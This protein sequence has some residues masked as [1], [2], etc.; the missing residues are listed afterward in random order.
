MY[1]E[2]GEDEM[3]SM[4]IALDGPAGAGKST[5]AK[6]ISEIKNI[7]YIDTGAMYRA[8]ALKVLKENIDLENQDHIEKMLL[9]TKIDIKGND[10]FLDGQM[11]TDEIRNPNV[12]KMVSHV[13]KILAVREKMTYL[14]R[15]IAS[16]KD[17]VMDGRDIGTFVLPNA[18]YKFYLTA[19]IE[20]RAERRYIELKEKG[21]EV[22]LEQIKD[23]I[24]ERDK[25]DMEREIAP[26]K[27][28]Q[29]AIEIDT[30]GKGIE[31][32]IHEILKYLKE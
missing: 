16:C 8:I 2:W 15:E 3:N 21:F 9:S 17:V 22:T 6:K 23:E 7:T 31:Q 5:I 19:S 26:L 30:T 10:I 11:V 28:A 1:K 14:Q 12:N 27:K 20:E 4:S 18:T 32:V 13:A 25:M 29:D 24:Q